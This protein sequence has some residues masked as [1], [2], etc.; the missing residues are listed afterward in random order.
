MAKYMEPTTVVPGAQ[1][2]IDL[3]TLKHL[4]DGRG[5]PLWHMPEPSGFVENFQVV[6]LVREDEEGK[7]K[8][9]KSKQPVRF[10]VYRGT[11]ASFA[12]YIRSQM[13]RAARKVQ[14]QEAN[15]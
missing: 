1:K 12:R 11:S 14:E 5:R 10:P 9:V 6:E 15:D 4:E 13:R 8:R 2:N 7:V 3:D